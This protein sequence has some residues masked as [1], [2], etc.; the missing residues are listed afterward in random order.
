MGEK[1]VSPPEVLRV[2]AVAAVKDVNIKSWSTKVEI[3][4]VV[5]QYIPVRQRSD[6]EL[7]MYL[8]CLPPWSEEKSHFDSRPKK[9]DYHEEEL[10][11]PP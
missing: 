10:Q 11:L 2:T 3:C 4:M 8:F 6:T 1:S 7:H 9:D 5:F